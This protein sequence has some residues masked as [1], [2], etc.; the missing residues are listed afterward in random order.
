MVLIHMGSKAGAIMAWLWYKQDPTAA[1]C[2][3]Q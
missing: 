3:R 1:C 2:V